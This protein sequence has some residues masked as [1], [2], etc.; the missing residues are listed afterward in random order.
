[1]HTRHA[2]RI[3]PHSGIS[4][5]AEC[6]NCQGNPPLPTGYTHLHLLPF[7][8]RSS[9]PTPSLD[10]KSAPILTL[11]LP[12]P[13]RLFLTLIKPHQ[14]YVLCLLNIP[15]HDN[16]LTPQREPFHPALGPTLPLC[17]GGCLGMAFPSLSVEQGLH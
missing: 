11:D 10:L 17:R 14:L 9:S 12:V 2:W 3:C 13:T 5:R 16:I 8:R 6:P 15:L 4:K 1:M 7:L